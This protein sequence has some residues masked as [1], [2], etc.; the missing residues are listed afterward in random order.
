MN[1]AQ[2]LKNEEEEK[3]KEN[4]MLENLSFAFPRLELT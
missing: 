2:N 4:K 3:M 1:G